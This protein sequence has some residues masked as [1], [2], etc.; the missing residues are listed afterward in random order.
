MHDIGTER[1]IIFLKQLHLMTQ[2]ACF[3][4]MSFLPRT[5]SAKSFRETM[6]FYVRGSDVVV[7]TE[8]LKT[9]AS[10]VTPSTSG[11]LQQGPQLSVYLG[12]MVLD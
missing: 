11:S 1:T 3:A 8:P 6:R 5:A 9:C 10:G 4:G 2:K 12:G 7:S